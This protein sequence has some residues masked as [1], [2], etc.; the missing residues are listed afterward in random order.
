[1][2]TAGLI[3]KYRAIGDD[4]E[5]LLLD[6]LILTSTNKKIFVTKFI[7]AVLGAAALIIG[8]SLFRYY[9][10]DVHVPTPLL[11]LPDYLV[12]LG[13]RSGTT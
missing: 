4:A 9:D 10:S 7:A 8:C 6:D 1:M 12:G 2:T 3:K 5:L 13:L 11:D